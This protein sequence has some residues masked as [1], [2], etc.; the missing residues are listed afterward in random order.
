MSELV[1]GELQVASL[2][3]VPEYDNQIAYVAFGCGRLAERRGFESHVDLVDEAHSIL[4]IMDEDWD[5]R[6]NLFQ[7]WTDYADEQIEEYFNAYG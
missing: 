3:V 6:P 7:E 5:T 1:E 2:P 4:S